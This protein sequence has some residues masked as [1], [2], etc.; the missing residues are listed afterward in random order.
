MFY[1]LLLYFMNIWY[2]F[3]SFGTFFS[4][5]G[6]TSKEK[7][8]NPGQMVAAKRVEAFKRHFCFLPEKRRGRNKNGGTR[9]LEK[10]HFPPIF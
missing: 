6:I 7:S 9:K 8:G 2:I 1:G 10:N 5:F 4:S 3:C